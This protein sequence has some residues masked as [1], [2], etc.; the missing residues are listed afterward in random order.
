MTNP[1]PIFLDFL[2][3]PNAPAW[4]QALGSIASLVAIFAVML[5]QHRLERVN[6]LADQKRERSL[7]KVALHA[8]ITAIKQ[9]H[10][11][12]MHVFNSGELV[13]LRVGSASQSISEAIQAELALLLKFELGQ[14]EESE[15][16][17]RMMRLH[18]SLAAYSAVCS[19]A[20]EIAARYPDNHAELNKAATLLRG[21]YDL[22]ALH[23]DDVCNVLCVQTTNFS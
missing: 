21:R 4:T 8:A 1:W 12:S 14:F 15:I 7:Q 9:N 3:S 2:S 6:Q 23:C 19:T 16:W 10:A 22:L 17:S 20:K 18:A 11:T 5:V 13:G